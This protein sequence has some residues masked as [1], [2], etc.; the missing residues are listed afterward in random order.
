MSSSIQGDQCDDRLADLEGALGGYDFRFS[1]LEQNMSNIAASISQVNERDTSGAIAALSA[2]VDTMAA[3][4]CLAPTVSAAPSAPADSE[5]MQASLALLRHEQASMAA[6]LDACIASAQS[7]TQP[8][9]EPPLTK[10]EADVISENVI[11]LDDQMSSLKDAF[12]KLHRSCD[13]RAS[14][15]DLEAVR[16]SVAKLQTTMSEMSVAS[17]KTGALEATM[18]RVDEIEYKVGDVI[19]T[20]ESQQKEQQQYA[21]AMT[22]DIRAGLDSLQEKLHAAIMKEVTDSIT[23]VRADMDAMKDDTQPAAGK[24]KPGPKKRGAQTVIEVEK[25]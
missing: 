7:D 24:K 15:T 5:S 18:A 16:R 4:Q 10:R 11:C 1:A 12:A 20:I 17:K 25:S 21:I 2:R 3:Q 19:K 6:R 8:D 9:A 13:A 23:S 14:I 22:A